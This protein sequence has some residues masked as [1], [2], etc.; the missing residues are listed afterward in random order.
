MQA[1]FSQHTRGCAVG[2]AIGFALAFALGYV[3]R[4]TSSSTAP[5]NWEVPSADMAASGHP[6]RSV[7]DR[8]DENARRHRLGLVAE[9]AAA[10]RKQACRCRCALACVGVRRLA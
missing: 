8:S 3:S 5:G 7:G 2:T 4:T 10:N 6:L 1:P 9:V